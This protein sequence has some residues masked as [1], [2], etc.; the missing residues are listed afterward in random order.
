MT[1][2]Q[3]VAIQMAKRFTAR[4]IPDRKYIQSCRKYTCNS[5]RIGY[6]PATSSSIFNADWLYEGYQRFRDRP[7]RYYTNEVIPWKTILE[8]M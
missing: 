4:K 2:K 3:F 1:P 8:H 7:A 5:L 6:E